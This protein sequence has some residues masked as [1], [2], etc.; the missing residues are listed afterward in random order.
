MK[1]RGFVLGALLCLIGLTTIARADDKKDI[2][3]LYKKL[4]KAM[5]AKDVKGIMATGTKD[6]S[7]T[8]EG[9]TMT[10]QQVSAQMQQQ[11]QMIQGNPKSKFTIVSCKIVGKT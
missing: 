7:Y 3:A 10:G 5:S 6:F 1:I 2:E 9:K 8:G 4:E 11:F